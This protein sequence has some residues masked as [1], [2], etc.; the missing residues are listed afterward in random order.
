M[1]KLK[2][3]TKKAKD[4]GGCNYCHSNTDENGH[5]TGIVY[6]IEG[7]DGGVQVRFC[8]SCFDELQEIIIN[9]AWEIND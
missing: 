5:L 6:V 2:V 9:C 8:Q 1:N 4:A 7:I 3:S